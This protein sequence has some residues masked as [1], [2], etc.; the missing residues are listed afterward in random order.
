MDFVVSMLVH[1]FRK[2]KSRKAFMNL[3][4]LGWIFIWWRRGELNPRP[5]IFRAKRLQV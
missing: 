2:T 5:K 3:A 4:G 1:D